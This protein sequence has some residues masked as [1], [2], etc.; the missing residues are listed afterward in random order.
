MCVQSRA[1]TVCANLAAQYSW[2]AASGTL[3]LRGEGSYRSKIYYTPFKNNFASDAG[4]TLWN[5][6]LNYEP[7]GK[8]GIYGAAFVKNLGNKTYTK[9]IFDPQ[10]LGY[11]AYYAPARTIG[12]Q[13]GYR[14]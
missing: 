9:A 11:L 12:A 4:L 13:A 5:V 8:T 10:G 3:A 6:L 2:P 14:Y 1:R 7:V